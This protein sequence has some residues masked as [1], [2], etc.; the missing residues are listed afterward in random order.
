MRKDPLS[1]NRTMHSGLDLKA[2][3]DEVLS[4]F[5]GTVL[6]VGLEKRSGRYVVVQTGDYAISYCHL[7]KIYV[8]KGDSISAGDVIAISGNTG[9]ST[10][11]HLH[12]TAK[13]RG[14]SV[15]PINLIN[16]VRDIRKEC[17]LALGGKADSYMSPSEIIEKYAPLAMRYQ[18]L[19]GIPSSVTLAQLAFESGW[20]Q[21]DL[22]K[23]GNNYFGI[24]ANK[25]WL[26]SG[27]PYRLI[28]DDKKSEP[29]C[30]FESPEESME[31]RAKLLLDNRY[32]ECFKHKQTD[33]HGWLTM[34][35]KCGYATSSSYVSNCEKIIKQHKLYLYD[36]LALMDV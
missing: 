32:K 12:I 5:E 19:Y 4:M 1:N 7:S 21:S 13:L 20:G 25:A 22:A 31:Y 30:C 11:P 34:L 6:Q 36:E 28:D 14:K 3:K 27:K 9:R 29:F 15:N 23:E 17:V 2:N 8:E 26:E 24:K 18:R 35:K 33:Y 16:Y 10:G